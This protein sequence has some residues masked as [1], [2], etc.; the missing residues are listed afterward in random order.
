MALSTSL[1]SGVSGMQNHQKMLDVI[2]NNISNV[3][4]IGYK[5][6]R[7]TF[8]DTFNQVIRAG[9]NPTTITGGTN[10]IQIGLGMKIS[11][12]DRNWNQ[13]TFETTNIAS[14]LAFQ[15]TGMFILNSNG[16]KYYSRAGNF[17][18]D[19]NGK[20][21]SSQNGAVVQGKVANN[22][23][24][25]PPGNNLEDIKIDTNMKLPAVAT[26]LIKWGGNLQSNSDLTRTQSVVQGGNIS[27]N[28]LKIGDTST[29]TTVTIY[30]EYGAAYSLQMSYT[31]TSETAADATQKPPV[32][33]SDTYDLGWDLKDSGGNEVKSGSISGLTYTDD[34][35]GNCVLDTASLA[36]FDGTN[37]RVDILNSNIDF[38][39]DATSVTSNAS[40]STLSLSADKNRTANVVSGSV[41]IYDS[42]GTS[43]EATLQ[44]TKIAT[45]T[46]TWTVSVPATSTADGQIAS[47]TGTI[48]FN[49]DGSVDSENISPNNPTFTFTPA[50]GAKNEI[51][52][53][54]FGNGFTGVT[55][56]SSSS[57]MSALSQDGSASASLSNTNIDEYG[58]MVGV[59]SNG[60]S[61]TLAQI[62]VANF[63]NLD[64]LISEGDNMYSAYANS[65][66]PRIS[67]L[68][69]ESTT[70][71]QSGALEQSNVDL[72]EEFTQM[73]VAQRG[74]QANARVVTTSDTI[75][76]EITNLIRG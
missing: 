25:V 6:S 4:T 11:S 7:V 58:N 61:K 73:I 38:L 68:G 2:G 70:T 5:C 60:S 42:L 56:T 44:F 22:D 65:G 31:K 46:W 66:V 1:F 43:H 57:V 64:G 29:P 23:G 3:N 62:M 30:N 33:K 49:S 51:I 41:S 10:S 28:S 76:Q 72:S 40:T 39:F 17:T 71:I 24:V 20:L 47:A 15:G 32:L 37:N 75:L 19:A 63:T 54:D 21:V 12:I 18:F 59:F 48:L 52:S 9:S 27:S 69:E 14:D 55:Q 36:K 16:T 35:T 8:S 45:N 26:T 53:L 13:G 34:G 74:F 50:G 67:S